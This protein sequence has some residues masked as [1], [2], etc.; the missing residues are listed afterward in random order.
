MDKRDR[1]KKHLEQIKF[2]VKHKG[3]KAYS[4]LC[5][6]HC[7]SATRCLSHDTVG[8]TQVKCQKPGAWWRGRNKGS[9][10]LALPMQAL[11]FEYSEFIQA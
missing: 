3:S 6:G 7:T 5:C 1:F 11:D 10:H 2:H 8:Q 4:C 9:F